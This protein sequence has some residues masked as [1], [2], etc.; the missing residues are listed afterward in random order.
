MIN[1]YSM[2]KFD[3]R[4]INIINSKPKKK[5]IR[6]KIKNMK[7]APTTLFQVPFHPEQID[8]YKKISKY[9]CSDCLFQVLTALGLR[10]YKVSGQDSKKIY[11]THKP[12][13]ESNDAA[14]YL[15]TIFGTSIK[16]RIHESDKLRSK[17]KNGYATFVCARYAGT[18]SG[19]YFIIY[20]HDNIIRCYD[21]VIGKNEIYTTICSKKYDIY[22]SYHNAK[23]SESALIK[24]N[25]IARIRY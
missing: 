22:S 19:H 15:S 5:V 16:R 11:E 1:N 3:K 21:P 7:L 23:K 24:S 9:R 14:K 18:N 13:V 6:M 20:K 2:V 17:L 8:R 25:M 10:H 12:G 4:I